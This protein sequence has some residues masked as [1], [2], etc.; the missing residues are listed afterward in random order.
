MRD[1]D[2]DVDRAE[3]AALREALVRGL[4]AQVELGLRMEVQRSGQSDGA[5]L[6]VDGEDVVNVSCREE[7][8]GEPQLDR[9]GF[10]LLLLSSDLNPSQLYTTIMPEKR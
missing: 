6:W 4:H 3:V 5:Q 1:V 7:T 10:T 8:E 2:V 9:T